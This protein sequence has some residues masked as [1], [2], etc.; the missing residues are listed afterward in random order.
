MYKII[1]DLSSNVILGYDNSSASMF[2]DLYLFSGIAFE[3]SDGH[4]SAIIFE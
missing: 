1:D 3:F 2:I 4:L